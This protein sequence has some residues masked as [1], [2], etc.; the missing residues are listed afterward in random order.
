[1]P[2][3]VSLWH[4]RLPEEIDRKLERAEAFARED[5]VETHAQLASDLVGILAPRMP[6]D[7]AIDRYLESM[8]L[9]GEDAEAVGSR[10]VAMLDEREIRE[11]LAREGTRGWGFDWR[12]A[13]PLGALRFI[14]RQRKRSAEEQL[15]LELAAARAE[16]RI[17]DAHA[18]HAQGFVDVL[19]EEVDPTR[20]V[21]LYVERLNLP[22]TRARIVYQRVLAR[23]AESLLPRLHDDGAAEAG[24]NA[25]SPAEAAPASPAAG[26]PVAETP[27]GEAPAPESPA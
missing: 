24:S 25:E 16:E 9:E 4:Q 5:M 26:A 13:T 10:A 17:A 15:W 1:M 6:F 14:Q 7:E 2:S 8:G 20:A 23:L 27:A 22:E 12:Y 11:D 21:E 18:R 19:E 3:P